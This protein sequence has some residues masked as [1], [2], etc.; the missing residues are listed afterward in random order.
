MTF[1]NLKCLFKDSFFTSADKSVQILDND[2]MSKVQKVN[3]FEQN[4]IS[5][6]P[7]ITDKIVSLFNSSIL[8]KKSDGIVLFE[9][10]GK[11]YIY[12]IELKSTF[13]TQ[14]IFK[15]RSQILSTYIKL[16]I[17]LNSIHPYKREKYIYKGFIAAL[18]PGD[19]KKLGIARLTMSDNAQLKHEISFSNKLIADGCVNINWANCTDFNI[20]PINTLCRFENFPIYFIEVAHGNNSAEIDIKNYLD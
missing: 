19:D 7:E 11:K 15:A 16:N 3:I 5:I 14:E 13:S 1:D 12:I 9:H 2:K 18:S 17:L 10:A 20:L 8:N 6:Q 4:F